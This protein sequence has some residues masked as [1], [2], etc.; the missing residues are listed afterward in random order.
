MTAYGG[1]SKAMSFQRMNF[2]RQTFL[3]HLQSKQIQREK[4]SERKSSGR[5]RKKGVYTWWKKKKKYEQG[6]KEKVRQ[7]KVK[8]EVVSWA[9][10]KYRNK[11][12]SLQ[13][14]QERRHCYVTVTSLMF[15]TVSPHFCFSSWSCFVSLLAP[16]FP[17]PSSMAAWKTALSFSKIK[18]LS[19]WGQKTGA[20]KAKPQN[21]HIIKPRKQLLLLICCPA[22]KQEAVRK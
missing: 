19:L 21:N 5:G 15:S 16:S 13:E 9:G 8:T 6:W 17:H 18:C 3:V 10:I 20:R 7:R 12:Q 2:W 11:G 14:M 4:Y 1:K 22:K